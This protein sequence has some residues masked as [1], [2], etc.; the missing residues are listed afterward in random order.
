MDGRLRLD[1]GSNDTPEP[2]ELDKDESHLTATTLLF[3]IRALADKYGGDTILEVLR[4]V[5]AIITKYAKVL[6]VEGTRRADPFLVKYSEV[7]EA[8]VRKA[9]T[10]VRSFL[11][12]K[13]F[14]SLAKEFLN[15]QLARE[16]GKRNGIWREVLSTEKT[17]FQSLVMLHETF[18]QPL[19]IKA[20]ASND[21]EKILNEKKIFKI[22]RN[23]ERIKNITKEMW[24]QLESSAKQWPAETPRVGQIFN[25]LIEDIQK[26]YVPYAKN[27]PDMIKCLNKYKEKN[28][29]FNNFL[30]NAADYFSHTG[31]TN[32]PLSALL[33]QPIVRLSEYQIFLKEMHVLT[34]SDHIDYEDLTKALREITLI[35]QEITPSKVEAQKIQKVFN[36]NNL[37][38][39]NPPNLLLKEMRAFVREGPLHIVTDKKIKKCFIYL[40]TDV[41]VVAEVNEATEEKGYDS[42]YSLNGAEVRDLLD[43]SYAQNVFQI[44]TQGRKAVFSSATLEEK[45]VLDSRYEKVN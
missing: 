37:L 36:V 26:E 34:P 5:E 40:F 28:T 33:L 15:S 18:T 22:F 17:Y 19:N 35:N 20:R 29:D 44:G 31:A 25:S 38:K 8:T 9:Q 11:Q 39:G 43:T 24:K 6:F 23:I 1:P 45:K 30:K 4:D 32:L 12:R 21:K 41:V 3:E 42:M 10:I 13:K 16:L 2:A 27:Y 7:D 14:S